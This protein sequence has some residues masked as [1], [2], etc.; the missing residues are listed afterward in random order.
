[1]KKYIFH[2]IMILFLFSMVFNYSL[3]SRIKKLEDIKTYNIS[4][5][6]KFNLCGNESSLNRETLGSIITAYVM[7]VNKDLDLEISEQIADAV[8]FYSVKYNFDIVLLLAIIEVE[9]SF[10]PNAK[11][12]YGAAGLTQVVLHYPSGGNL[13]YT[14]L[15]DKKIIKSPNDLFQIEKSVESG[16]LIYNEINLS[17]RGYNER[18]KTL[19]NYSASETYPSKIYRKMAKIERFIK[20]RLD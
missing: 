6:Y 13:W 14:F 16:V 5:D 11:S 4:H 12:S 19:K 9:S 20:N 2:V 7:S 17:V 8:I 18:D 1:M 15:Y 3:F 10:Y